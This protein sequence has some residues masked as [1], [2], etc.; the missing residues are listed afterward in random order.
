MTICKINNKKYIGKCLYRRKAKSW[1]TYLGSGKKLVEDI[2]KYGSENFYKI[3]LE[4][5]ETE[6]E[7]EK[8]EEAFIDTFNAVKSDYFYNMKPTSMG[9]DI[10][11]YLDDKGASIRKLSDSTTGKNNPMYQREKT[12]TFINSVK[13]SNSRKVSIDNI[14]YESLTQYLKISGVS[15]NEFRRKDFQNSHDIKY[16]KP[17][18][19]MKKRDPNY[20]RKISIDGIIYN[21]RAEAGKAIH[22]NTPTITKK[23]NDENY[24]NYQYI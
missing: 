21:N 10:W 22:S 5:S 16:L 24:P 7:L 15:F 2:K 9:G 4:E 18:K 6:E 19:N 8:L 12:E 11:P 14:E 17:K 1:E 3:I 13:E 23:L 20:G